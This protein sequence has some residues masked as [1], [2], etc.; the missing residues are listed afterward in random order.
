MKK[1]IGF[2]GLAGS[3]KT[4]ALTSVK[5][6]GEIITMGDV[7]R[8]E[9]KRRNLIINND[10]LGKVAKD[11][12]EEFGEN[13]IAKRCI[14]LINSLDENI[15]FVD[16]LRS[17]SEVR[18]FK[19]EWKFPVIAIIIEEERRRKLLLDRAR[20][21]DPKKLDDL[22]KREK[23]EEAFGILEVIKNAD[24][25]ILNDY[26]KKKLKEKT[27]ELVIKILKKY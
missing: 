18:I 1:V 27:R 24:Y 16:G 20:S 6:I 10:N 13:I 14:E 9:A 11:L 22:I 25:Q 5:E 4:T 3:G 17:K 7:V 26:S 21:D 12:R 15:V 19:Q 23:R 8:N 2:S